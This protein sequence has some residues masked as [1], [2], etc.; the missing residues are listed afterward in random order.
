MQDDPT[1]ALTD[2]PFSSRALEEFRF[3]IGRLSNTERLKLV[4]C[5]VSHTMPDDQNGVVCL[6][7]ER[8]GDPLM[9]RK[10]TIAPSDTAA[11][12]GLRPALV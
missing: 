4:E 3:G 11:G 6:V 1:K 5:L 2:G 9:V 8:G 7:N 12:S 10:H